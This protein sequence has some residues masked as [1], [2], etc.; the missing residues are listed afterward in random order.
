MKISPQKL[1][2]KNE[3]KMQASANVYF[4][5]SYTCDL[6]ECNCGAGEE[7]EAALHEPE[8]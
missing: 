7:L 5:V 2:M 6:E 3:A 1:K 8:S 4:A